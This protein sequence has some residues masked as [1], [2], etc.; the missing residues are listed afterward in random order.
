[1]FFEIGTLL[2]LQRHLGSYVY[3]FTQPNKR[4]SIHSFVPFLSN[5]CAD[6]STGTLVAKCRSVCH[7]RYFLSRGSSILTHRPPFNVISLP[8]SSTPA[9]L[10][11]DLNG[12]YS[13]RKNRS[14]RLFARKRIKRHFILCALSLSGVETA[15]VRYVTSR[16]LLF[17]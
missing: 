1:M 10:Q 14:K 15:V 11:I 7:G 9:M 4:A 12:L 16:M 13:N 2:P 3:G 6:A 17:R 5:E 8:F